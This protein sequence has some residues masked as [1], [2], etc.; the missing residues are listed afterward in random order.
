MTSNNYASISSPSRSSK[1]GGSRFAK[2]SS[3]FA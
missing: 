1:A 2:K 3:T